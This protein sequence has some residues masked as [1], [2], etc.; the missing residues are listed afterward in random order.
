[1]HLISVCHRRDF[2]IWRHSQHYIAQNI[3][4]ERYSVIVDDCDYKLFSILTTS[5]RWNVIK[6]SDVI[7]RD[8]FLFLRDSFCKSS[9]RLNLGWYWQQ[10]LKM[11]FVLQQQSDFCLIWDADTIPFAKLSFP[12]AV[13]GFYACSSEFH[14]PYWRLNASLLGSKFGDY[15]GFSFISQFLGVR[16][17]VLAHMVEDIKLRHSCSDW[18]RSVLSEL[19]LLPSRHRLSEYEL[20]GSYLLNTVPRSMFVEIRFDW[21]RDGS[22]YIGNPLAPNFSSLD[23]CDYAAFERRDISEWSAAKDRVL[24]IFSSFLSALSN[25][26][27]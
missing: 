2:W 13:S 6:A 24:K 16:S 1:M 27:A 23:G 3:S 5:P 14:S 20:I 17:D 19:L 25:L 4:A 10:Y 12:S 26:F 9:D 22:R 18:K 15:P 8:F 7:G 21:R 11:E